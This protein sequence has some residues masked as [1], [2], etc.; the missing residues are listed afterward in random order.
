MPA[1]SRVSPAEKIRGKSDVLFSSC[2]E[3]TEV[4]EG[5][6]R[7]GATLVMYAVVETEVDQRDG[8]TQLRSEVRPSPL[9]AYR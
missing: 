1:A 4:L 8:G 9:C 7:L 2:R 6:A 5:V 3:P